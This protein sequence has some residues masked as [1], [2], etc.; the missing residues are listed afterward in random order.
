MWRTWLPDDGDIMD[1][2]RRR[3]LGAWFPEDRH[4]VDDGRRGLLRTGA[5]LGRTLVLVLGVG[6]LRFLSVGLVL[7]RAE[8]GFLLCSVQGRAEDLR[9]EGNDGAVAVLRG[10]DEEGCVVGPGD[11][12]ERR[13][14]GVLDDVDG[15]G[16]LRVIHQQLVER[17]QRVDHPVGELEERPLRIPEGPQP[18]VKPH[19][20]D[21][22][23]RSGQQQ[24]RRRQIAARE[25]RSTMPGLL[26]AARRRR[27]RY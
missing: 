12:G 21:G 1:D 26:S 8:Q 19:S 14:V 20:D 9:R 6:L 10:D 17:D 27:R 24:Y 16:V 15:R 25:N 11:V 7:E 18:R 5:I 2:G 22:R 3:G 13:V 23:R 4:V